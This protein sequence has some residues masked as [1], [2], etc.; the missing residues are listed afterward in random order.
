M[1]SPTGRPPT[2]VVQSCTLS[3]ARRTNYDRSVALNYLL[4]Y[5]RLLVYIIFRILFIL[6]VPLRFLRLRLFVLLLTYLVLVIVHVLHLF[7]VFIL[8]LFFFHFLFLLLF[9][10]AFFLCYLSSS[11]SFSY[12][13]TSCS[14]SSSSSEKNSMRSKPGYLKHSLKYIHGRGLE[15]FS[16]NCQVMALR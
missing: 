7:F 13:S 6:L 9:F 4:I 5:L 8:L 12:S 1:S 3:P 14:S 16:R 10:F 11:S 15:V 2:H